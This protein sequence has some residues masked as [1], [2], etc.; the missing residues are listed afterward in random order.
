MMEHKASNILMKQLSDLEKA[1]EITLKAL[2][3][4]KAK[5]SKKPLSK[6][7]QHEINEAIKIAKSMEKRSREAKK[8]INI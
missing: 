6:E 5:Q 4:N 8:K 3:H 7:E 1:K 2:N